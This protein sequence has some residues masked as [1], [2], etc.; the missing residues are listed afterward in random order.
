MPHSDEVRERAVRLAAK[1]GLGAAAHEVGADRNSVRNWCRAAGVEPYRRPPAPPKPTA[2]KP[3]ALKHEIPEEQVAQALDVYEREGPGRAQEA[4][5]LPYFA[6][7]R[8]ARDAQIKS[9]PSKWARARRD[10]LGHDE[11]QT[12]KYRARVKFLH[13]PPPPSPVP[14]IDGE[15]LIALGADPAAV[16]KRD[17]NFAETAERNGN[18]A[19]TSSR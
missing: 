15:L 5:G 9:T 2:L 13:P 18:E 3:T 8:W 14:L 17:K 12:S 6:I 4:T 1:V 11:N 10:R 19:D 16:R 7:I